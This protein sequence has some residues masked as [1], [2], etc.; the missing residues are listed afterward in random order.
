MAAWKPKEKPLTLEEATALARKELAPFW[1]GSEPLLAAVNVDG[2]A[3]AYPID[4]FI[5]ARNYLMIF[6]DPTRFG[7]E[8]ASLYVREW[9]R[10][11]FPLELQ[12]M[13]VFR[14]PYPRL[15]T[16]EGFRPFLPRQGCPGI[17]VFDHDHFLSAAF[18]AEGAFPKAVLMSKGNKIWEQQGERW[19][20]GLEQKVQDFLRKSDPGL[21]LPPPMREVVGQV[22]DS[23]SLE[24]KDIFS[25]S[26]PCLKGSWKPD[27]DAI[28]ATGS[29][30]EL[31]LSVKGEYLS[32]IAQ[33]AT[34]DL[35]IGAEVEVELD[36]KP[37]Y[38]AIAGSDIYM[39]ED[40][41]TLLKVGRGRFYHVLQ[42]LPLAKSSHP[43]RLVLR[44]P[45]ASETTIELL[46]IREGTDER[47]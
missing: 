37:V 18:G 12:I 45:V 33:S 46:G 43:H 27:G 10:R 26:P 9:H 2:K 16:L 4:P 14:L 39:S 11:Y 41:R 1:M 38:E 28:V 6:L 42:K 34:K 40:G 32:M 3:T 7:G 15:R 25:L 20:D 5:G 36:G 44:F 19:I 29:D 23:R 35:I 13:Q 31:S 30:A 21:P 8:T 47:L 22:A 24:A 17:A